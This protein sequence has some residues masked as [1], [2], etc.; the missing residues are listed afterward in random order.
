MRDLGIR[1]QLLLGRQ[2]P[3]PAPGELAEALESL[4]VTLS[5]GERDG[6]QLSFQVGR[7]GSAREFALLQSGLLEPLG[8]VCLVVFVHGR[9]EVLLNGLITRQ[10]LAPGAEPG[11]SRLY[12][13]GEDQRLLM[14][15]KDRSRVFERK[16]DSQIVET[17][18]RAYPDLSPRVVGTSDHRATVQHASDLSFIES[19]ASQNSFVFYSEPSDRPGRSLAYW[20]PLHRRDLPLLPPLSCNMGADSTAQQISFDYN[21]LGRVAPEL[22][23]LDLAQGRDIEISAPEAPTP[24]L[25]RRPHRA[26]RSEIVRDAAHLSSAHGRLRA[27]AAVNRSADAVIGTGSLDTAAYG[28]LLRPCRRVSVRGV[29]LSYDGEYYVQ[30]VT[31]QIRRGEYKQSFTLKREGLGAVNDKVRQ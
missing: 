7:H 21:G 18:L 4:Q 29:G 30:Q 9:G 11:Q 24:P 22:S 16:S 1:L 28:A 15:L 23:V 25:S 10:Q 13:T 12:V 5:E 14:D 8:R 6:F 2:V 20:G 31:H 17:V 3:A 26:L 19:L 27:L